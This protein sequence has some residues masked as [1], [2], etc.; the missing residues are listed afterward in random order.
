MQSERVQIRILAFASASEQIG[1]RETVVECSA[2][3]TPQQIVARLCP[4][5]DPATARVALDCEYAAWNAPVDG[6]REL[7]VLPP[8][9]GG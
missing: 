5:F 3:D 2:G 6:A 7:A 8:V 1:I 4:G 9:S